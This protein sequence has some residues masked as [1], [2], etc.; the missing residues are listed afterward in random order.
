MSTM[1]TFLLLVCSFQIY[2]GLIKWV[3]LNK[4][5]L[6]RLRNGHFQ[7]VV[8]LLYAHYPIFFLFSYKWYSH[9]LPSALI[10]EKV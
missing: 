6:K 9:A 1:S 4:T 10:Q 8:T 2:L 7:I 3:A 5:A